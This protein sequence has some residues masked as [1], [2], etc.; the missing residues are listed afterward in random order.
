MQLRAAVVQ[1]LAER[2]EG[3][4]RRNDAEEAHC[5]HDAR[6]APRVQFAE[7][8]AGQDE[9]RGEIERDFIPEWL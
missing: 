2:T 9:V 3:Q 6:G 5:V 1:E 4:G 7:S 8:A